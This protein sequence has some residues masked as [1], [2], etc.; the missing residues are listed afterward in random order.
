M[1]WF[2]DGD[3]IKNTRCYYRYEGHREDH[4]LI[5]PGYKGN[6][7]KGGNPIFVFPHTALRNELKNAHLVETPLDRGGIQ[8]AMKAV[9]KQLGIKKRFHA[10][11]CAT[12]MRPICWNPGLIW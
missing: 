10:T 5:Y 11:H 6:P 8:V 3:Q 7:E 12:V 2:K 4:L 9:V 1:Y